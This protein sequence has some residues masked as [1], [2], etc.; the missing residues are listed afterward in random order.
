MNYHGNHGGP[1][2]LRNWSG[3]IIQHW[4][5]YPQQWWGKDANLG[6]IGLKNVRDGS[7]ST[8]LFS[9]KLV[10][11]PGNE[12]VII[13]SPNGKRG[14]YPIS[15]PFEFNSGNVA[16]A[17]EQMNACRNLP[18]NTA[19]PWTYLSGAHWSLAYPWHTTNSAYTHF[20][21][22][23]KSHC[24]NQQEGFGLGGN[25]WGGLTSMVTATSDHPGGVNVALCDGSV[26]FIKDSIAHRVWWAL[27]SRNGREVVSSEQYE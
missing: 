1:G 10:G 20:M 9:E 8:A 17:E 23:N 6:F 19:S 13:N 21:T 12:N 15:V 18:G 22:P 5:S 14:I 4:T 2:V 16:L 7:T 27:G 11:M 26:K 24:H 25:P 3:T